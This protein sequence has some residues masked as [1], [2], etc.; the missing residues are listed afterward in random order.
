M[1]V[2]I[3]TPGIYL[4]IIRAISLLVPKESRLDW[5]REWEAE[6]VSRW[7]LLKEWERLNAH[8]KLDLFKKVQGSFWDILSFQQRG[9]RLVL[10]ALNML[11]ALL[12]G[13]GAVQ[14]FVVRG[15]RDR[16]MQPL[17]LSLAA[18]IVSL[19]FITSG[20]ALLWRWPKVRRL[21]TLTG[22]LSILL[23]VY[24]VLPPHRNMG[25]LALIVGAGYGLV[26][27][28]VF[29]WNEKRNLV[30]SQH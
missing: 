21:I 4:W 20:I 30:S 12:T 10:V 9:T 16:Q 7:L 24:G 28:V 23:H 1:A 18:I 15:I 8:T 27:L 19:L 29:E 26:M 13:F 3:Q 2:R 11:V 17:L 6:I 22:M 5:R 25:F 14:Q